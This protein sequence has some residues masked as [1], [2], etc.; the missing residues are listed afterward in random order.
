MMEKREGERWMD[1]WME[2][3]RGR[4]G[5]REKGQDFGDVATSSCCTSF[6]T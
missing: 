1:A 5:E 6:V 4:E 3:K 2:G